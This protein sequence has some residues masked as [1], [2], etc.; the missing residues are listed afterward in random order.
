MARYK[1]AIP[2]QKSKDLPMFPFGNLN[3]IVRDVTDKVSAAKKIPAANEKIDGLMTVRD[4]SS[5]QMLQLERRIG[6]VGFGGFLAFFPGLGMMIAGATTFLAAPSLAA[7][8]GVL[9]ATPL[10]VAGL[11]ITALSLGALGLAGRAIDRLREDRDIIE[12][13]IHREVLNTAQAR[14]KEADKSRRFFA[15][16]A[17]T[18]NAA[19]HGDTSY[20]KLAA[21]AKRKAPAPAAA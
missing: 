5:A 6:D 14:P 13:H 18:Y 8:T 15:S 16:L 19:S 1:K 9:L 2:R 7:V 11:G 4:D 12:K 21:R 20:E 17:G 3:R 10:F